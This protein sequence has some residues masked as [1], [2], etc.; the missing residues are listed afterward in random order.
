MKRQHSVDGS[1]RFRGSW[2]EKHQAIVQPWSFVFLL[3]NI[4]T[5]GWE[6]QRKLVR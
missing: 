1:R 4:I 3:K 5:K 6:F 2:P